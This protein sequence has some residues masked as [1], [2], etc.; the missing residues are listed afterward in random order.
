[1]VD[2]ALCGTCGVQI[3]SEKFVADDKKTIPP[4]TQQLGGVAGGEKYIVAG[5]LFKFAI[6]SQGLYG[7]DDLAAKEAG[8]QLKV[9]DMRSVARAWLLVA[10][11]TCDGA[12]TG[13]CSSES[14][15]NR[16]LLCWDKGHGR[17]GVGVCGCAGV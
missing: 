8:H 13:Q 5:I 16:T 2:V 11:L 1:M 9:S 15:P 7:S 6:D 14:V 10:W 17:V 4:L 3:I 12:S